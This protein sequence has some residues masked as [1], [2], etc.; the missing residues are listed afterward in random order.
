M[1][2]VG[3]ATETVVAMTLLGKGGR[4]AALGKGG[5]AVAL[6]KGGG[7]AALDKGAAVMALCRGGKSF[8]VNLTSEDFLVRFGMLGVLAMVAT[9]TAEVPRHRA[10]FCSFR[11]RTAARANTGP[12]KRKGWHKQSGQQENSCQGSTQVECVCNRDWSVSF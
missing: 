12:F 7:A 8:S 11:I 2:A 9:V 3:G 10:V 5:G 6:G 1:A 4:A